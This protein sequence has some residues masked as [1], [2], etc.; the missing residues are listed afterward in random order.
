MPRSL[1]LTIGEVKAAVGLLAS[2]AV[3]ERPAARSASCVLAF[4]MPGS[5]RG[6][7]E[8]DAFTGLESE[9]N[10]RQSTS[11]HDSVDKVIV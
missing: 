10:T 2:W 4:L 8:A 7:R 5:V 6:N 9:G 3:E 11:D 1:R